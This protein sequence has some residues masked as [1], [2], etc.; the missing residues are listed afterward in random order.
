MKEKE[1]K[2]E[3]IAGAITLV[4]LILYTLRPLWHVNVWGDIILW[5]SAGLMIGG[6]LYILIISIR[7]FFSA[8]NDE[9]KKAKGGE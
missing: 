3:I 6:L 8:L 4:G 5:A 7:D 2:K 9:Y 1:E